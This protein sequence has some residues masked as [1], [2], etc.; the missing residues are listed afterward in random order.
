MLC[1]ANG[2][3]YDFEV[4]D[5]LKGDNRKGAFRKAFPSGQVPVILDKNEG[6]EEFRLFE[7][8]AI[9][10]YLCESRLESSSS[11]YPQDVKARAE[12]N[13]WMHWHHTHSRVATKMVL[14]PKLYP[15][16]PGQEEKW[17][18]GNKE[19]Q[20]VLKHMDGILKERPFLTGNEATIADLLIVAEFDQ[21]RS[22]VTGLLDFSPFPHVEKWL[23]S[24]D[25]FPWYGKV[26][27]GLKAARQELNF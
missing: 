7:T 25:S 26:F 2:I 17:V 9:L 19:I 15:K 21:H 6:G 12:I 14:H 11:W 22:E 18:Q 1:E 20:R 16:L 3:G 10:A 13:A 4:V 27:D 8:P 5:A 23:Y 24:F